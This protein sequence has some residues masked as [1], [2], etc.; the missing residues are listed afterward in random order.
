LL[1]KN[2]NAAF[3]LL[4]IKIVSPFTIFIFASTDVERTPLTFSLKIT[5]KSRT[6]CA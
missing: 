2:N 3:K 5:F 1:K 6:A 4:R